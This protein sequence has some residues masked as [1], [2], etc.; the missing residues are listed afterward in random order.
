VYWRIQRWRERLTYGRVFST[1]GDIELYKSLRYAPQ[2][3]SEAA[4]LRVRALDDASV[5]CRPRT[6]DAKVLWDAFYHRFHLPPK[7]LHPVRCIVDLGANVGYT[8][9]HFAVRYPEAR[10]VAVEMDSENAETC[11]ANLTRLGLGARCELLRAA[12]WS[13]DGEVRYSGNEA[14]SLHVAS[15]N[16]DDAREYRCAPAKTLDTIF[17]ESGLETVDYLKMDIEGAEAAVLCSPMAWADRVRVMKVEL[18]APAT[19]TACA[20]AL[21]RCG[22]RCVPDRF[23]PNCLVACRPEKAA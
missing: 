22:F 19:F 18:H 13:H 21:S 4:S 10:I 6:T 7:G 3:V 15:A 16:A 9:A 17:D 14:W 8:A 12:V 1:S 20:E 2:S 23:H 11:A 5:L